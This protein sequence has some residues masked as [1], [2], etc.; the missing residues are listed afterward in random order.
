MSIEVQRDFGYLHVLTGQ[1]RQG[2]LEGRSRAGGWRVGRLGRG[3]RDRLRVERSRGSL[4][5]KAHLPAVVDEHDA[6]VARDESQE[7]WCKTFDCF[8]EKVL[9]ADQR[10]QIKHQHSAVS[11]TIDA[12][13]RQ[14]AG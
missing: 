2:L 9:P 6:E 14:L 3:V 12:P 7:I 1:P 5:A 4:C 13:C 10:L 8:V 11:R